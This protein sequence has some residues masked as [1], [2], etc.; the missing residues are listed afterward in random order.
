[1]YDWLDDLFIFVV[2][3][4]LF[5][6][7]IYKHIHMKTLHSQQSKGIL[8]PTLGLSKG[9]LALSCTFYKYLLTHN[10][11]TIDYIK[12]YSK[13]RWIFLQTTAIHYKGEK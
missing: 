9:I 12:G 4:F 7:I 10:K 6:Y 5:I 1:M 8:P 3:I 13:R 2:Y 11:G